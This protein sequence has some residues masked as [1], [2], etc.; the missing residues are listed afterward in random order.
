[1]KIDD[2]FKEVDKIFKPMLKSKNNTLQLINSS[3][4]EIIYNDP[5]RIK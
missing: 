1:M 4:K 5:N 2:I 3:I